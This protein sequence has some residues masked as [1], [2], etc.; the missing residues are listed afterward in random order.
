MNLR[1]L[2]KEL[3]LSQTTV[4]RALNGFPE[5]SEDT[6]IR[7]RAAAVAHGYRPNPAARRLAT[8]QSGTIGLIFPAERNMLDDLI[9]TEFLAGCL[10]RSTALGFDLSLSMV[11]SD[12]TE[13]AAY[14]QAVRA[15]KVDGVIL[16]S[17][18]VD[19]PRPA[20]LADIGLPFVLHGR[21]RAPTPCSYMDIDNAG[22]FEAAT[23]LL[24]QLGHRGIAMLNGEVRYNFAADREDGYRAALSAAGLPVDPQLLQCGPMGED[25]GYRSAHRLLG[26]DAPPTA[27]VCSS[28]LQASGVMKACREHGRRV[29]RDIA[30]IAHDDRL[31]YLRAESF[32]PPLTTTQS[33]IGAAGQRVA[34]RLIDLLRNPEGPA[35][36]EVWPVDLVVRGSTAP[37]PV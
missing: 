18:L 2:S 27:F 33:S 5:V 13:A 1:Q 19:D 24:L 31:S 32:D 17:P 37:R 28:V 16:S 34:E 4:S 26:A 25:H 30:L 23:R 14:R 35:Q 7:V 9:F 20:L 36:G 15:A 6:R 3:G 8:G 29:G 10:A 21:T 12:M 22:A 11:R